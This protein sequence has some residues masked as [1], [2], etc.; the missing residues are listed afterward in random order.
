MKSEPNDTDK[1]ELLGHKI[2]IIGSAGSGK[3]TLVLYLGLKM[4]L[5]MIHLDRYY[6]QKDWTPKDNAEWEKIVSKLINK[7]SWIMDGN[8]TQTIPLRLKEATSVIFLDVSR[9]RCLWRVFIRRFKFFHNRHR[10]DI[11]TE[12]KERINIPFYRWIW[13]FPSRS[14]EK[15]IDELKRFNGPVFIVKSKADFL[16]QLRLKHKKND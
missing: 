1:F 10:E 7:K 11:P 8:Y 4:A 5:P 14:R 12:C 15:I 2:L 3:T 6:W 13:H 9:Y 16:N